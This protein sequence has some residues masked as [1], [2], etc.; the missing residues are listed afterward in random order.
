MY[1]GNQP[2]GTVMQCR[3]MLILYVYSNQ[4]LGSLYDQTGCTQVAYQ[5]SPPPTPGRWQQKYHHHHHLR[6][7]SHSARESVHFSIGYFLRRAQ[8]RHFLDNR[9]W[10]FYK[11]YTLVVILVTVSKL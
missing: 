9:R 3:V 7:D 11:P 10:F 2:N 4:L 8:K 6:F 5:S 1:D